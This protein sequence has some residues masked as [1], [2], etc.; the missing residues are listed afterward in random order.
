MVVGSRVAAGTPCV[1]QSPVKWRSNEVKSER[2]RTVEASAGFIG[3]SA[4]GGTGL[5][6]RGAVRAGSGAGACSSDA[7]ARR[8]RGRLFLPLFKRL[9]RSQACESCHESCADLFLAPMAI[10]YI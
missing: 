8:T 7:R 6:W 10:S 3:T 2:G 4:G 1:E 9:Q 5:A